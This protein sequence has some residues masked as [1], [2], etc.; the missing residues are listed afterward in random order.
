MQIKENFCFLKL[1]DNIKEDF[2]GHSRA[3]RLICEQ[4]NIKYFVKI[5]DNDRRNDLNEIYNVYYKLNIPTAKILKLEYS[6]ECNKTLC[7][8]EYI[9]G[10]TLKELA[11]S[12]NEQ[13]LEKIGISVG[14]QIKK[15]EKIKGN[16]EEIVKL[17][18]SELKILMENANEEQEKYKEKIKLQKI[19]LERL[20]NSLNLLKKYVYLNDP[21]FIHNDVNYN[22]II[23]KNNVPYFIDTDGAKIKFRALDFRGNCWWTWNGKNIRNEQAVYRGIYL[24]LFDGKIPGEFHK[25]LAFTMI[26]EFLL[27]LKSYTDNE[28]EVLYTFGYFKPIFDVT[29]Y[30]ENYR[31]SWL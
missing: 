25:E 27:R 24:G 29:N 8:Y 23:I 18:N 3:I 16:K 17:L 4:N 20:D 6:P 26:Y 7:A 9:D 19:D 28:K 1:M 15:F 5:Y 12:E 21:S 2:R 11:L 10:K 13:E 30:F 31:F 14:K 22:N